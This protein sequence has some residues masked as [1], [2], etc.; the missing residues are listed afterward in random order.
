[1]PAVV[2]AVEGTRGLVV[3]PGKKEIGLY[4]VRGGHVLDEAATTVPPA[5]V[6]TAVAGL[7]WRPAG[8]LDDWPWLAAWLR[9]PKGRASYVV[10]GEATD[11]ETLAAAVHAVLPARFTA[12]AAGVNVETVQ[13]EP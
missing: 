8:G 10:A 13:G 1:V 12:S 7:D 3:D 5:D 11:R 9:S 4:P 6:E 2:A